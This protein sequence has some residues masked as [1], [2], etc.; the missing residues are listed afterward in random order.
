MTEIHTDT[1][2]PEG[3]T[4]LGERYRLVQLLHQRPRLNLYI[5]QRLS[6]GTQFIA[7]NEHTTVEAQ[8]PAPPELMAVRELVLTGLPPNVR[9]QVE[10]A[11]FEEFVSPGILG[12]PRLPGAGDRVRSEGERHYLVMQLRGAR[13]ERPVEAVPLAELLLSRRQW[14][15]WLDLE[16]ALGWGVQLCRI[17]A[18]LHRLG[19]VLGDL[20]PATIL[21]DRDGPADWAP[22]LLVSWPPAPKFWP[23]DLEERSTQIFPVAQVAADNAFVA[24]EMFSRVCDEHSD[25]YSLGAILYLLLTCY[26]PAAAVRRQRAESLLTGEEKPNGAYSTSGD[27]HESMALIPPHLFNARIPAALEQVLLGALAL[28]PANRYPSVFALIEALEEVELEN[29]VRE[30]PVSRKVPGIR[31]IVEWMRQELN[32]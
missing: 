19:V 4:I 26:A 18:R 29:G 9:K 7:P 2:L 16:T 31:K 8:S 10:Q 32:S 6:G 30:I 27:L 20:D 11:A 1:A 15:V 25:V 5:A 21:V 3:T 13:G 17:V 24:P 14:P 22:V 28:N 23:K 12:S